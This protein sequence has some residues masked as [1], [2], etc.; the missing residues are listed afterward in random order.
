MKDMLLNIT[1]YIVAIPLAIIGAII[2]S[3]LAPYLF[4]VYIP[5]D[6]L[7]Y[8]IGWYISSNVFFVLIPFAILYTVPP[9]KHI[10]ILAT[11]GILYCIFWIG[12]I[13]LEIIFQ[14]FYWEQLGNAI[15]QII[16]IISYLLS[17][18]KEQL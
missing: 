8:S 14:T 6:S 15:I 2:G 13:I 12:T 3:T 4:V 5:I 18:D 10:K 11:L 1:R 9:K 7:A 16:T 17:L